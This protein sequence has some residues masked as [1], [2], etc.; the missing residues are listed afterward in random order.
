MSAPALP[1]ALRALVDSGLE[2]QVELIKLTPQYLNTEEMSKLWTAMQSH[3]RPTAA[4]TASVVLIQAQQPAR[5]RRC[6][7]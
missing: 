2:D 6:R 1:P 4:Y 5:G 7:C 3:F